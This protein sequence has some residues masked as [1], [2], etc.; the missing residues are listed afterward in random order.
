MIKNAIV[1]TYRLALLYVYD[2]P[3]LLQTTD[4]LDM[5]KIIAFNKGVLVLQCGQYF[6]PRNFIY[7]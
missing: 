6:W 4:L 7:A 3:Q 1:A 5:H 2:L